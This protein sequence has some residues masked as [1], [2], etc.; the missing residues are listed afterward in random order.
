MD[1]H[2]PWFSGVVPP[3]DGVEDLGAT[4]GQ[5]DMLGEVPEKV[6]LPCCGTDDRSVVETHLTPGTVDHDTTY[7]D[8]VSFSLW[9][10]FAQAQHSLKAGNDLA[11]RT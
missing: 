6:E 9:L 3:P 8:G 7:H 11:I 1:V 2:S 4:Q 5:T 10:Q